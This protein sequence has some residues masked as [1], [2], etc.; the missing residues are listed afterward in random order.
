[1]RMMNNWMTSDNNI[2]FDESE[3]GVLWIQGGANW[4]YDCCHEMANGR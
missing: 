1:M 3:F 4:K 2:Y